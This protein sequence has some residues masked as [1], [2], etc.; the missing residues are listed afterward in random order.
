MGD[1]ICVVLVEAMYVAYE[2]ELSQALQILPSIDF[3]FGS[4][5]F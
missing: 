3:P 5:A 4:Q 1:P 2:S